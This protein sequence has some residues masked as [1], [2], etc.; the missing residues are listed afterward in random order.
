MKLSAKKMREALIHNEE[1]TPETLDAFCSHL[2]Y[3]AV[4]T[5]DAQDYGKLVSRLDDLHDKYQTCGNTFTICPL[6]Q[7]FMA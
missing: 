4:N 5:S 7:V 2:Y 6:R 3:Q 1:T